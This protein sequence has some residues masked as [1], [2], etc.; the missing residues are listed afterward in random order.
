MKAEHLA[1]ENG[2]DRIRLTIRDD[3]LG[4][5][6]KQLTQLMARLESTE[7]K[8]S[9]AEGSVSAAGLGIG[10]GNIYKRVRN[11][12]PDGTFEIQS[13]EGCGTSILITIPNRE[14][15]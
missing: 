11:L 6:R 13:A 3:G 7:G 9:A 4:M 10:L 2:T 15:E 14:E 1:P 8:Q 5:T 12:Y